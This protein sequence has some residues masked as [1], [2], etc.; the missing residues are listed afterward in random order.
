MRSDAGS[1][2]RS[3][4]FKKWCGENRIRFTTTAPKH[5]G[6]NGLVERHW[7]TIL[8]IANIMILHARLSKKI[9][10]YTVKYAQFIHDVN[11]VRDLQDKNGL[12]CTPYQLIINQKPNVRHYRVFG[13]PTIFKR[14]EV[15]GSGK[16]IE[17]KYT[18][19]G[20]RGIFVGFP[21]DSSG[22]LFYVP[23]RRKAYISLHEFFDE[24]FTSPP[25]MPDLPFQGAL[26]LIS[27][28]MHKMMKSQP[29]LQI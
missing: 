16:R 23:N 28:N 7:G 20:I 2:F 24:N 29:V 17:N 11:P 27:R 18:Q 26:K 8:K 10:Y 25:S 13:C 4:T 19:Q 3:D 6:Q 5:Q 21:E 15:S 14:Y 12:P 22:W 1:E 9:F